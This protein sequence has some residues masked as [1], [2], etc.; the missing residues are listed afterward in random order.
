MSN[1]LTNYGT[2]KCLCCQ[3]A[4]EATRPA[5]V[6]CSEK[7]RIARRKTLKREKTKFNKELL[8]A[9]LEWANCKLE[10]LISAKKKNGN[11]TNAAHPQIQPPANVKVEKRESKKAS[12]EKF[13]HICANCGSTFKS[14]YQE[15][16]YCCEQ[17][18]KEA[19]ACG[20]V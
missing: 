13:R 8:W 2:R 19:T 18:A 14:A 7:C 11:S 6:T 1:T 3:K 9:N 15:D 10:E 5:Q 17:C 4:F 20:I 12:S 16:S